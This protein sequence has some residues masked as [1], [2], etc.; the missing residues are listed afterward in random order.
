MSKGNTLAI[1]DGRDINATTLKLVK[2]FLFCRETSIGNKRLY[3]YCTD[4]AVSVLGKA[5]HTIWTG[6]KIFVVCLYAFKER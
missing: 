1:A 3:Q 2:N 6:I 4:F 5:Y